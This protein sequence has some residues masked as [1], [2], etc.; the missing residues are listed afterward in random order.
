MITGDSED[1]ASWVSR[2]LG[3]ERILRRAPAPGESR[4]QRKPCKRRGWKVAMVGDGVNDAPALTQA[5][6]GI[7][8]GAGTNVAV[9]SADIIL[10][11]NDPRGYPQG[12]P[13]LAAHLRQDDAEPVLG[14]RL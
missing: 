3:L 14:F 11:K 1:V 6:I 7:A 10:V 9:E 13:A 5:D 12:H 4:E 8:I 2:E